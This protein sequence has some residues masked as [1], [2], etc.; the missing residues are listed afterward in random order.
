MRK[1]GAIAVAAIAASMAAASPPAGRR[2]GAV[3]DHVTLVYSADVAG[4]LEPCG[5]SQD[6][7]GGLARAAAVLKKIRAEGQPVLFLGG[8]DLLF[9]SAPTAESRVQ[10]R[11]KARAVAEALRKM[12]LAATVAGERD[13]FAGEAFAREAGLAFA[14]AR[15]GAVGYGEVGKVPDAPVRVGVLHEGG[16]RAALLRAEESK[17]AGLALLLASHRDDP[18][19]DDVNRAL[20]DA[21]VPVVQVQGRGQSLARIDLYLRGD[22]S[23]RFEIVPGAAERDEEVDLAEERRLEYLRRREAA[24]AAGQGELARALAAKIGDLEALARE[25][26]AQPLPEPP[27][28]R[29]SLRVSFIPLVPSLPEDR[30]VRAVVTRYYAEVAER[31]LALARSQGKP[32]PAPAAGNASYIGT[33]DAPH[34]AA[35][36]C[37]SCHPAAFDQWKKTGH[38]AAFET[39]SKAGRQFDLDCISC[40]VTGWRE[41][42]GACNLAAT[43]GRR[44]VQCEGCHGPASLHAVDPP[45]HI[46]RAPSEERCRAC[47]T[48]ERSTHFEYTSYLGRVLGPGHGRPPR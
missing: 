15:F 36:A 22:R 43:R 19:A 35:Q 47:H 7:R 29:P 26:R 17:R 45:G 48:P 34:G 18:L 44:N 1:L 40:H 4:Y 41:P 14:P 31:N 38:A 39:L 46:E 30:E 37:R 24:L 9:E 3:P 33:E 6:Q 12:G 8:G 42:G 32:C 5:C 11:L 27:A 25:L 16:T 2:T 13:L 10:D 28:D 20:L 21:P 23:R